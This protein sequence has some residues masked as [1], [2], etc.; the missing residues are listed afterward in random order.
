MPPSCHH[1]RL[2]LDVSP[3]AAD[4]GFQ[5]SAPS[6]RLAA[7]TPSGRASG[8]ALSATAE[9]DLELLFPGPLV[10]PD[11]ALAV[12]PTEPPQSLRSWIQEKWR[13]PV[14]QRRK[15]IYVAPAPRIDPALAR[16][17][18][19]WSVPS[20]EGTPLKGP[21]EA[22]DVELVR[23]YLE[24]FYHPLPVRLLPD[25]VHFV[26]WT[27]GAKPKSSSKGRGK[28]QSR[29]QQ[30]ELGYVGLQVGS[31]VT[32]VTTRPSSDGVFPRQLNLND[33]LDAAIAAL[34]AD[35]YALVMLVTQDI[36]EDED[37]DFCCGRAYGS[38]RI[39]VVSSARYHPA[40]DEHAGVD[41]EHAWPFSHCETY[42]QR[43]CRDAAVTVAGPAKKRKLGP[44]KA[45]AQV[46][47][48]M[49]GVITAAL[50]APAPDHN[51]SAVW[52]SRV[53]RTVAHEVGHC[54]CLAHCPYYACSM[55]STT[56]VAED[57]RQPPYLCPVCLA[58]LTRAVRDVEKGAFD[59]TRFLI[60]RY[61]ALA[62]FSQQWESVAMF[63]GYG[64]WLEKRIERLQATLDVG[65]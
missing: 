18:D 22:P 48:P 63:A 4:A 26:P 21:C 40:L 57:L 35:A 2:L 27:E 33:I 39:A 9:G 28:G 62:R 17:A 52:L 19:A 12:D 37:D 25:E 47:Q 1:E 34:P 50:G 51:L 13:N 5:R 56:S 8:S 61:T 46:E 53:V 7:T 3:H 14:T 45:A 55:Q 59:E 36:Y 11:D 29:R 43:I 54:F 30:S 65:I 42:V 6:K 16:S 49:A 58:K 24:A 15:T 23:Q 10:L 32:R 38:S 31:G 64:A 60:G 20:V 41:V 44:A